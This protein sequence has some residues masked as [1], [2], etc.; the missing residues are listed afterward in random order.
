MI[1][2]ARV[3]S[4]FLAKLQE[5]D[6]RGK[7]SRYRKWKLPWSQNNSMGKLPVPNQPIRYDSGWL[8]RFASVLSPSNNSFRLNNTHM[9]LVCARSRPYQAAWCSELMYNLYS[10][11]L[12]S[13]QAKYLRSLFLDFLF[14]KL[15]TITV[16][17]SQDSRSKHYTGRHTLEILLQV[18]WF[19]T[20]TIK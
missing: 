3:L 14:C 18:Q 7:R 11:M 10:K 6:S 9:C 4:S 1:G 8:K 13:P 5:M 17:T 2:W 16:S 15:G 12:M 20:T 19:Q